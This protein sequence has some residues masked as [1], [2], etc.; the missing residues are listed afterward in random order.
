MSAIQDGRLQ[1]DPPGSPR[2]RRS[3]L[4]LWLVDMI[5]ACLFFLVPYATELNPVTVF[6]YDLFGLPGVALAALCYAVIVIAVGNV[7]PDPADTGFVT[8]VVLVYTFLVVNNVF[9]LL[10]ETSLVET[11]G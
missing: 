10:S 8:V 1:V 9:L 2:L 4:V 7:L 11:I 6:T 5:A 3:F